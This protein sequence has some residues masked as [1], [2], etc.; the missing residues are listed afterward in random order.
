MT[1]SIFSGLESSCGTVHDTGTR[2]SPESW[3][4]C[5]VVDCST[6]QI[7]R[8]YLLLGLG[9][10]ILENLKL[11]HNLPDHGKVH[12]TEKFL[13][14]VPQWKFSMFSS[15]LLK[16][17]DWKYLAW[18]NVY[19][20]IEKSVSFKIFPSDVHSHYLVRCDRI[21]HSILHPLNTNVTQSED[22][23]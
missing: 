7:T 6:G 12:L 3:F 8:L 4:T 20:L 5:R 18:Q 9:L 15:L 17:S 1:F 23:A 10:L 22:Q 2:A 21:L 19:I 14:D 16:K 13:K 11:L